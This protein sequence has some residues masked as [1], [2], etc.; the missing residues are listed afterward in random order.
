ML[1]KEISTLF[2]SLAVSDDEEFCVL[3]EQASRISNVCNVS[4]GKKKKKK[5]KNDP[6]PSWSAPDRVP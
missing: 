2:T 3:C 6:G 5:K 1:V 4:G